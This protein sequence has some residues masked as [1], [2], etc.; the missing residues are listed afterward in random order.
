MHFRGFLK[1]KRQF[2][3]KN[4]AA[5]VIT[6]TYSAKM[7]FLSQLLLLAS[8]LQKPETQV[9]AKFLWLTG[10]RK[11]LLVVGPRWLRAAQRDLLSGHRHSVPG[12]GARAIAGA[13][14]F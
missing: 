3:H 6:E 11:W 9:L 5:D 12:E 14:H 2:T 1:K 7:F 10:R 13:F 4:V 8:I